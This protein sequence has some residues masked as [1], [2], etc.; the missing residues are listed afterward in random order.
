MSR[1]TCA[2]ACDADADAVA[3]GGGGSRCVADGVRGAELRDDIVVGEL[4]FVK[5]P[6]GIIDAA[7]DARQFAPLFVGAGGERE[8]AR[9]RRV[10][11]RGG[12]GRAR[13]G[14]E[15]RDGERIETG[16]LR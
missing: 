9:A 6:D 7:G 4:E 16:R 11:R 10:E 3:H 13:G 1:T 5:P 15:R 14:D 12:R 8:E 2:F